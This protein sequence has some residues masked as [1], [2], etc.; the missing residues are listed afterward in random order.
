MMRTFVLP[1]ENCGVENSCA[2]GVCDMRGNATEVARNVTLMRVY[3]YLDA[4]TLN[5]RGPNARS[6][7]LYGVSLVGI[8][9]V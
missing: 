7:T 2:M 5:M 4:S 3:I 8:Y 1:R 9:K 6:G